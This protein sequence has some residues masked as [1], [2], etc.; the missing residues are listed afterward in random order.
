MNI[1]AFKITCATGNPATSN[2]VAMLINPTLPVNVSI[3]ALKTRL[4]QV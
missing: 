4:A 2:A 3:T 1:Q